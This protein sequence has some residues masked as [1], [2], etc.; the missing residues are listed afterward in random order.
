MVQC[1]LGQK[2]FT[3]IG[4]VSLSGVP[5]MVHTTRT[6]YTSR[7]VCEGPLSTGRGA[8]IGT[9][10]CSKW[11]VLLQQKGMDH[12]V[13]WAAAPEVILQRCTTCKQW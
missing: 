7:A 11:V 9:A 4:P 1:R 10:D 2:P 5:S 12:M 8:S 6:V 13:T 3:L